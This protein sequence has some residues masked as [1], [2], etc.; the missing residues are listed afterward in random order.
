MK[1]TKTYSRWLLASLLIIAVVIAACGPAT[2]EEAPQEDD[3]HSAETD[4]HGDES[5]E[6][7]HDEESVEVE[8]HNEE[9]VADSEPAET[10]SVEGS[11]VTASGLEYIEV[12]AGTGAQPNVGDIVSVHYTGTL[13]D[14]TE[15]DSSVGGEPIQFPLGVGYVI[16]GWDEGISLMRE[17]GK[18]QLIIP[19][20][21]GYGPAGQGSI[22]PDATLYFDV[23]LVSVE[24]QPTPTPAPPPESFD[25]GDY[26]TTDSGIKYAVI[27]EGEGPT[28]EIGEVVEVHFTAWVEEDLSMFG[29]SHNGLPLQFILGREEIL[30]GWDEA[31]SLMQQGESAQFIL[32]PEL[33]FGEEGVP[34]MVPPNANVIFELDLVSISP[35]PP[36]PTPA[37]PPTNIDEDEYRDTKNG[38]KIAT[39]EEG[40]GPVP[41]LGDTVTVHYRLWLEDG[42]QVD[43]SYDRGQ[44]YPFIIGQGQTIPGWEEGVLNMVQGETAQIIVPPELGYGD[45]ANGPIPANATLIFEITIVDI[46]SGE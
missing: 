5:S 20:E 6:E 21:L 8:E 13:E 39:I 38:V 46:E 14:G 34:G 35:A 22:P 4:S 1:E 25:E 7:A 44:P 26:T 15:F 33:A 17:G 18:A 3:A 10:E 42:T 24:V 28:A 23:E 41:Q 36:T 29:D 31:V 43:N 16:P 40:D 2:T 30:A 37:P 45:V 12:E 32:P 11:Q 9:E 27:T 19:S